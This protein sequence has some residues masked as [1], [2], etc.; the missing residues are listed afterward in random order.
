MYRSS[1]ELYVIYSMIGF[2]EL[3][4]LYLQIIDKTKLFTKKFHRGRLIHLFKF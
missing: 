3:K 1:I 4:K 2:R